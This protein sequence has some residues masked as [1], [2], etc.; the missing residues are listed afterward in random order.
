MKQFILSN[1]LSVLGGIVGGVG[2]Y[3]YYLIVGC[4][5]G[6][7]P[8]TSSPIISTLWGMAMGA[9]IFSM[10]NKKNKKDENNNSRG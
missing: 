8:I 2:G 6:S 7:C 5:T 4:S 9:L 1:L 10:F 3:L